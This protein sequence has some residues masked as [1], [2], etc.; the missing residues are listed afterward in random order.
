MFPSVLPN[1]D[2]DVF[3]KYKNVSFKSKHILLMLYIDIFMCMW[4]F[5]QDLN[6][7]IDYNIRAKLKKKCDIS[8]WDLL[9]LCHLLNV[10]KYII[11]MKLWVYYFLFKYLN[12]DPQDKMDWASLLACRVRPRWTEKMLTLIDQTYL[13][14]LD[15]PVGSDW[16]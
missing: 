5:L 14:R 1:K 9:K 3:K 10:I 11:L 16:T 8:F 4:Y 15:G 6:L 13:C 2:G 7:M 12:I